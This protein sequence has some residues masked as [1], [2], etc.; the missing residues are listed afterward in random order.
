M[1]LLKSQKIPMPVPVKIPA[2]IPESGNSCLTQETVAWLGRASYILPKV[3]IQPKWLFHPPNL[4]W[5]F[6][7]STLEATE[8]Q[9]LTP[10]A[11]NYQ[12]PDGK[13]SLDTG[14]RGQA[15]NKY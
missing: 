12:E 13:R 7:W 4:V 10:T 9:E 2:K 3:V 6:N 5:R 15:I 11:I 14:I 1:T 8:L